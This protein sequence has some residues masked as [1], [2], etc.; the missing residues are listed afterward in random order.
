MYAYIHNNN[1][2]NNN[3]NMYDMYIYI[4]IY[5]YDWGPIRGECPRGEGRPEARG[6]A[7]EGFPT[8]LNPFL[9]LLLLLL[10]PPYFCS[11]LPSFSFR[12]VPSR[13]VPRIMLR[14][15]LLGAGHLASG[16]AQT[17][18][19]TGAGLAEGKRHAIREMGGAPRNLAPR[20]HLSVWIVKHIRLPLHRCIWWNKY[21][22]VPTL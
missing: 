13:P 22:R 15:H 6:W 9:L 17:P 19:G 8:N 11:F 4:Y 20:N 16:P 12:P 5:I 7:S 3:N 18:G 21:R 2:N 1:N 10:L 14:G